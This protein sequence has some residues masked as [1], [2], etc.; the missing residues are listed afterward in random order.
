MAGDA[1]AMA[2]I[3]GRSPIFYARFDRKDDDQ[4]Q[5]HY[6]PGCGHGIVTKLLAD[7]IDALG[8][9]DRT[10]LVSPVGCSV[11]GYDYVDVG[12]IQ[13]AHGRAPAV[14]TGGQAQPSRQHR[15]ELP[16]RRR[17]GRHRHG[18]DRP[19]GQPRR[20]PSPS[21]SSTTPSTA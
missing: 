12:N 2:V 1:P 7:A 13:A 4:D 6:C 21:S 18:R 11:F 5:T 8:I 14:A 10:I 15:G 3:H 20:E 17:P 16:G 9:Q 19:R